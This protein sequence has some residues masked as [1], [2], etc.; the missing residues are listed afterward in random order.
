MP[1]HQRLPRGA[2]W[3][4][5]MRARLA[6]VIDLGVGAKAAHRP[7]PLVA[8]DGPRQPVWAPRDYAAF[9]REGFMQNAIVYWPAPPI[10][11]HG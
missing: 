11:G 2:R 1:L 3:L 7:A 4:A 8:L 5:D 6:A 10:R 9:A